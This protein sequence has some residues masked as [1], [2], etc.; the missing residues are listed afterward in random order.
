MEDIYF[1]IK[2]RKHVGL[3]SEKLRCFMIE[4]PPILEHIVA[5][6]I[7]FIRGSRMEGSWVDV[8]PNQRCDRDIVSSLA[9]KFR[10]T[11]PISRGAARSVSPPGGATGRPRR[12]RSGCRSLG[13][14]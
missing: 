7:F 3:V 8:Q 1:I 12:R 4:T 5:D 11:G 2:V 10:R 9:T 6:T 13:R 14:P